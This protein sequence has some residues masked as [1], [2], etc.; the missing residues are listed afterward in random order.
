MTREHDLREQAGFRNLEADSSGAV[1]VEERDGVELGEPVG[2]PCA[3]GRSLPMLM[4]ADEVADLLR[5]SRRA[6]YSMLER[7]QLP[8]VVRIGR[9]VLFRSEDLVGWLAGCRV[10]SP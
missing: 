4:S 8:G 10:P 7:G 6:V 5:T 1:P 3:C 9:R 2:R